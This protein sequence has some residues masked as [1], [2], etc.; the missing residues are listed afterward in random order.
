[1]KKLILIVFQF[2]VFVPVSSFSIYIGLTFTENIIYT[3]LLLLGLLM[4]SILE[5]MKENS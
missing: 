5:G 3:V 1:M 4:F 2:L